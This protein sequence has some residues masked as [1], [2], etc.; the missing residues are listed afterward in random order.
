LLTD[1]LNDAQADRQNT[2]FKAEDGA[3]DTIG[4]HGGSMLAKALIADLHMDYLIIH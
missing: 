3:H 4:N 2:A 1:I